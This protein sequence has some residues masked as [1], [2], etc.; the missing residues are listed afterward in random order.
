MLMINIIMLMVTIVNSTISKSTS[1]A[2]YSS[3]VMTPKPE[4]QRQY[5]KD[6]GAHVS[7][8]HKVNKKLEVLKHYTCVYHFET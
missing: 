8:V 3:T 4:V 5:S 2:N 1:P 6:D 7:L